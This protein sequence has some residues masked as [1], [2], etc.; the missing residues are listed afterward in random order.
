MARTL[1]QHAVPTTFGLK[2][3]TWLAGVLDAYDD[4]AALTF[5]VQ[6]GGAAGTHGGRRRAGPRPGGRP[7]A[8]GRRLGLTDGPAWHTVR[9]SVTRLGD[10]LVR[11]TDAWGRI[12]K[13]VLTLCRPE[14]GEAR[15]GAGGGSSTMPQKPNPVLSVLIRRAALTTPMLGATLHLAAA[16]QVDER[17]DGGWH[18]EW[19]TLRDLV[20]R[21]LVAASQTFDL[22]DGLEVDPAGWPPPR[23]RRSRPCSPSSARWPPS[24]AG[25]RGT[26]TSARSRPWWT[27]CSTGPGR[28]PRRAHDPR[29]H[30]RPP[31]RRQHRAELPLLVLGPSLGTSARSL[32]GDCATHLT[33][34]FDV[35]AWDLPGHGHNRSVPEEPFTMAELAAGV[36]RSSTTCSPSAAS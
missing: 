34:A 2:A 33:D 9:S 19:A 35:L 31:E 30:R 1:T 10:A 20:R 4:V 13:D 15:E 14:I 6:I 12:A 5:P 32:W 16:P 29:R 21:T 22:L 11:C 8:G 18:A 23:R 25:T 26:T 17:A 7:G 28:S 27:P 3:A 36:L 24:P